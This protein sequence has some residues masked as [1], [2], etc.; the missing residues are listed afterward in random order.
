[1]MLAIA[2]SS[3]ARG[4][5]T[6]DDAAPATHDDVRDR[7]RPTRC[8]DLGRHLD[9]VETFVRLV[10]EF[11]RRDRDQLV[12]QLG[13]L[14]DL[15]VE[16]VEDLLPHRRRHVRVPTHHR[17]VRASD[18]SAAFAVRVRRPGRVVAARRVNGRAHRASDG[19]PRRDARLR[20]APYPAPPRR[21]GPTSRRPRPP[22]SV[23]ARVRSPFRRSASRAPP[24]R[25]T[26]RATRINVRRR[27]SASTASTSSSERAICTAPFW[28]PIV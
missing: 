23:A 19:T 25:T 17:E 3:P 24:R 20:R 8:A 13:E 27:T 9:E 14:R 6:I 2:R 28:A 11:A 15:D 5:S 18:S 4:A 12:D 10:D 7:R 1:M 26:P 16:V 22:S 21:A